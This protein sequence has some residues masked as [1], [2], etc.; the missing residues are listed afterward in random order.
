MTTTIPPQDVYSLP[1][2]HTLCTVFIH[3]AAFREGGQ[4]WCIFL[5]SHISV[6]WLLVS[7]SGD[8][9]AIL[10]MCERVP[11][12]A[13]FDLLLHFYGFI[14][15]RT[16][17]T[18]VVCLKH[19]RNYDA[20]RLSHAHQID[21]IATALISLRRTDEGPL[22]ATEERSEGINKLQSFTTNSGQASYRQAM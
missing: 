14:T 8:S 1:M 15:E 19:P 6:N 2:L 20:M 17:C 13:W 16:S 3:R 22:K 21:L 5:L 10:I 4:R 18:C 9:I 11:G 7:V 12:I